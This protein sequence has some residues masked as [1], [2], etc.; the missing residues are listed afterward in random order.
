MKDCRLCK[1]NSKTMCMHAVQCV[2]GNLFERT[3][4]A[5]QLWKVED[6]APVEPEEVYSPNIV[7][8]DDK[9]RKCAGQMRDGKAIMQGLTGVPDFA[10]GEVVT[11]SPGGSGKL[12]DCRKCS[13]CG[14]SVGK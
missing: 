4:Y 2:N 11:M 7:I 3:K 14:W 5:L 8:I 13:D 1:Y 6:A 12:I 10:D 9:C